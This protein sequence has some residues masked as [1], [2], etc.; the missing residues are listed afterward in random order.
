MNIDDYEHLENLIF[1]I[2]DSEISKTA[3]FVQDLLIAKCIELKH[4]IYL[5]LYSLRARPRNYRCIFK[6]LNLLCIDKTQPIT[7]QIADNPIFEELK[8]YFPKIRLNQY[9]QYHIISEY[10]P[11]NEEPY[12][13]IAVDDA[14][15]FQKYME[16]T[17]GLE[18]VTSSLPRMCSTD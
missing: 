18:P 8:S 4:F 13:H 5:I 12:N 15:S 9:S 17:T 3:I 2:N 16:P 6:L 14:V 10:F 11:F 7:L 1:E